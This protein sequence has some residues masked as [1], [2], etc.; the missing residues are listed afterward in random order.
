MVFLRVINLA[1]SLSTLA[2]N[3]LS[4]SQV[5]TAT[6][7]PTS[8]PT[9]S[10]TERPNFTAT[11]AAPSNVSATSLSQTLQQPTSEQ[12]FRA[13]VVSVNKSAKSSV[14]DQS[15]SKV[16]V[17]SISYMTLSV[18]PRSSTLGQSD[19][20]TLSAFSS[21]SPRST[22]TA[23]TGNASR[24]LSSQILL[25]SEVSVQPTSYMTMSSTPSSIPFSSALEKNNSLMQTSVASG[26]S[27]TPSSPVQPLLTTN[28][29]V[30]ISSN[31]SA[32]IVA[33]V[34]V[35]A[36]PSS[37]FHQSS[38]FTTLTKSSSA[39]Q[40]SPSD[41]IVVVSKTSRLG[42]S[43]SQ[44]FTAASVLRTATAS[45]V[46]LST[47]APF[48]MTFSG[49]LTISATG[50]SSVP[51]SSSVAV[52]PPGTFVRFV[53][54]VPLNQSVSDISF[55]AKVTKGILIAYE[56][57]TLDGTTGNISVKVSES[58]KVVKDFL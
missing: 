27:P 23:T 10:L 39:V 50:T 36:T 21:Q 3:S 47:K 15:S 45:S 41:E 18:T 22:A 33:S 19:L 1:G 44:T 25:S 16:S 26:M 5:V 37:K 38:E 20:L 34:N 35:S 2:T 48:Q 11:V 24:P 57:G 43:Q 9:E 12:S 28:T 58:K 4:E 42:T 46:N 13:T 56:N 49:H 29:S 14:L 30:E 51:Q 55:R 17:V 7:H 31:Q 8:L 53:I 54:S 52:I 40:S 6:L 32:A